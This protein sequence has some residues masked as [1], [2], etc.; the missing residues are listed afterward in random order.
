MEVSSAMP[1]SFNLLNF[2]LM[3]IPGVVWLHFIKQAFK[4]RKIIVLQDP[5][6]KNWKRKTKTE[7]Y[8]VLLLSNISI[9]VLLI[10]FEQNMFLQ[11][12]FFQIGQF[13]NH[14]LQHSVEKKIVV[15]KISKHRS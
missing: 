1:S 5:F 8:W 13:F 7:H 4:N 14:Y 9:L 11:N 6:I 15:L 12:E 2:S 10:A 3:T